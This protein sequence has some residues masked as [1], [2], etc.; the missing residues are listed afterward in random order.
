MKSRFSII[1][2]SVALFNAIQMRKK[3][4]NMNLL[5]CAFCKINVRLLQNDFA[6]CKMQNA[7]AEFN[8][9]TI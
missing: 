4:R 8:M 1:M 7:I 3:A 2:K 6:K 5:L 9:Q